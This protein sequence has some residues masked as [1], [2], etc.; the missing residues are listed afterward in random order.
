MAEGIGRR[1]G[2]KRVPEISLLPVRLSPMVWSLGGR[3]RVILPVGLVERLHR[4]AREVILAHELAHVRRKDHWVR[5]LELVVTTLFWWHPLSWWACHQLRELEEQCCDEL[6]LATVRHDAQAYV[7][8]LLDTVD[9]LSERSITMPL[10]ATAAK[11]RVS[12]AR[13]IR[14]L[15]NHTSARPLTARRLVLLF[16]VVTVPMVVAFAVDSPQERGRRSAAAQEPGRVDESAASPTNARAQPEDSR[17]GQKKPAAMAAAPDLQETAPSAGGRPLARS[18]RSL[19]GRLLETALGADEPPADLY[20]VPSDDVEDLRAF[21]ERVGRYQPEELRADLVHRRRAPLAIRKAAQRILELET[22]RDSP[23]YRAAEMAILRSRIQGLPGALPAEQRATLAQTEGH[24]AEMISAGRNIAALEL[25]ESACQTL[26]DAGRYRLAAEASKSLGGLFTKLPR[27]GQ[28][29]RGEYLRANAGWLLAKANELRPDDRQ[30]ETPPA[31]RLVLLD[32]QPV[33]NCSCDDLSGPG[34]FEGNGLAALPRGEQTFG[35]IRF[36]VGERLVTLGGKKTSHLP[37]KV[38]G[39]EVRR[40][41][42]RLY[43]LHSTQFAMPPFV[44]REGDLI[45]QYTLNYEDGSSISLSIIFGHHV[46]DWWNDDRGKPV[47]DGEVVWTGA[48]RVS[49]WTKKSLRLYLGV[50]E[51]PHPEKMVAT[52]DFKSTD[53]DAGPFCVALT[54]EMTADQQGT[55]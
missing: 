21:L 27:N 17:S 34:V 36:M 28:W 40:R 33:A 19:W 35:G 52:L 7:T 30:R 15:K 10:V 39:I 54:V 18:A 53:T 20:V 47:Q 43:A 45:G 38:E 32:L 4:E 13:R 31:D 9:F 2:M 14:M 5:W 22:D 51:N 16:S 29:M 6:V 26:Q 8:A 11:S 24:I 25:A 42:R 50:W 1:L 41:L 3:P 23:A 37:K 55:E 46:R 12:L 44:L 49:E 48:N